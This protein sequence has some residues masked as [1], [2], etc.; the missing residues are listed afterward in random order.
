ML[1][2]HS[3]LGGGEKRLIPILMPVKPI[4]GIP[5]EKEERIIIMQQSGSPRAKKEKEGELQSTLPP[6]LLAVT[7]FQER[8]GEFPKYMKIQETKNVD[9]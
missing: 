1:I 9:T 7:F 4:R 5:E 8:E 6:C 2:V 3:K